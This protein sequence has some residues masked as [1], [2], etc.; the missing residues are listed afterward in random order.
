MRDI[1]HKIA[2]HLLILFQGTGELIKVLRQF[3]QLI[4]AGGGNTGGEIPRSQFVRAFDQPF[5]RGQ[6]SA[7]EWKGRQRR[8]QG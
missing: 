3:A 2:T 1:G 6:Q 8:Q 5:D 4:G 7:R